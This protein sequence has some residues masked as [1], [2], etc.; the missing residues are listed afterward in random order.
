ML[1]SL[2][3]GVSGMKNQQISMDVIGNNIANVNTVGFKASRVTFQESLSQVVQN[4]RSSTE[5]LGGTNPM[6]VGLG[7]N[8]ASV[9]KL[10]TQGNLERTGNTMDLAIEGDGYFVLSNGNQEFFTR[11]GNLNVD[12]NGNLVLGNTGYYVQG[13]MADS[14]GA[15]SSAAEIQNIT[16]P[17]GQK[18]PAKATTT[19]SFE[20]NLNSE[21]DQKSQILG[22]DFSSYAGVTSA[23]LAVPIDLT[24]ANELTIAVDNDAGGTITETLTLTEASYGTVSELVAEINGQISGNTY[25][26][27][28]VIAELDDSGGTDKIVIRTTDT[29]GSETNITLSG[30]ATTPISLG[31]TTEYGTASTTPLADLSFFGSDLSTGD[32]IRI[33]G[34][35]YQG[36]S[37]ADVYTY[38][39]GDTVQDL[40]DA[41]NSVFSGASVTLSNDGMLRITD[42]V[43]GESKSTANLIYIDNDTGTSST[44]PV[45]N[46]TQE[47]VDAGTHSASMVTYDS[48]GEAHTVT[49]NFTNISSEDDADIWRWE[50]IVDDNEIIPSAGNRGIIKFNPNGSLAYSQSDDGQSLTFEPGDGASTMEIVLDVGTAGSFTGITQ[51]SNPMTAVA[52]SHDGY[53]MGDLYNISFDETGTITGYFTNGVS[54]E[55]AQV[56]LAT[57]NNQSGLNP[58]G[59]NV[60]QVGS[61]SGQAVKGWA[62]STIPAQ[63]TPNYLEMS[64]VDLTQEFTNMI[65]AQRGFQANSRVITTSDT[66]LQ[67]VVRLKQ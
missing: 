29:G 6:N 66:L 7:V 23:A 40:L 51:L 47:G 48:K 13:R 61:N 57:F 58:V 52:T 53:S 55:L 11:A 37:V 4:G 3:S 39:D 63:I 67:E 8:V 20:G 60:F 19:I 49:I 41:M 50:A 33:N 24:G 9:D 65:V 15:I 28:E 12:S 17:F 18:A 30:S 10:F 35:T 32:Q 31:T 34:T 14:N 27:G 21:T 59:E 43:S 56:A 5:N 16:L 26:T 25:L 62:Q 42:S 22:S 38:A 64:N 54:Q 46:V 36:E 44:L 2:F 1:R 45:F